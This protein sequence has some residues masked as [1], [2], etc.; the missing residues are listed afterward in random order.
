[1][2]RLRPFNISDEA[3]IVS[4]WRD[5]GLVVPHNDPHKDIARKL[6]VNPELFIVGEICGRVMASCMAGY[7]GHRGW[8]NYLAVAP[9]FQRR[10]YA[11]QIMSEVERMLR[12]LGCP[13]INLQIRAT[14][15]SVIAFYE[16]LGFSEDKALSFG[17]RLQNDE[18]G[19]QGEAGQPPLAAQLT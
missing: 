12:E 16:S 3:A 7:E 13:K 10:G 5:C 18:D 15:S 11:S 1:M 6:A 19:E 9:E 8:I 14:N 17:F 4:L 2:M